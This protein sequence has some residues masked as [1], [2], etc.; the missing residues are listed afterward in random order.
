MD[1]QI[2]PQI[3]KKRNIT[4]TNDGLRLDPVK[5]MRERYKKQTNTIKSKVRSK[6]KEFE[7]KYRY[8]DKNQ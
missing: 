2:Y 3:E 6:I 7:K 4:P 8:N 1:E 5:I